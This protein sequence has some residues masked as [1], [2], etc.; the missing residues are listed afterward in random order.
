MSNV[1]SPTAVLVA[2]LAAFAAVEARVRAEA[3]A[4]TLTLKSGHSREWLVPG[5]RQVHLSITLGQTGSGSGT[6]TLDPNIHD[7]WGS[8]CIAIHEVRVRVRL[9]QDDRRDAK[10]RRLYELMPV[11]DEDQPD[12]TGDRWLLVRPAKAGAP[13][14]LVF[15][16]KDGKMQDV[17]MLEPA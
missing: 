1:L 13:C 9:V 3:P 4:E 2:G 5:A 6:L 14:S 16:D 8:T 12:A 15:T 10:G 7:E 11:G 17:V